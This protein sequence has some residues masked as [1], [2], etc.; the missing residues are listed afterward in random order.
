MELMGISQTELR[1]ADLIKIP[2]PPDGRAYELSE[3]EL[4]LLA[5]AGAKH[6]RVKRRILR[7]LF[8]WEMKFERGETFS[9]TLFSLGEQTARIPDAAVLLS[10]KVA[11]LPDDEVPIPF[12]PDLAIE[13]VS[14]S[15]SARDAEKK[16]REYLAV[17]VREVWQV[18]PD[19]RL[20]RVRHMGGS[21]DFEGDQLLHSEVLLDFEIAVNAFFVG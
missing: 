9:E 12:G 13:V 8:A 11:R 14:V 2:A 7:A 4:V 3:G 21:Q 1:P 10:E 15:E 18:Y 5:N 16:V 6:E 20:V 19:E 17:G